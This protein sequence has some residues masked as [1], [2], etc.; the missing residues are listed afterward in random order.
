[1]SETAGDTVK[2]QKES[3]F[4]KTRKSQI[5]AKSTLTLTQSGLL[6]VLL[7]RQHDKAVELAERRAHRGHE[8][9]GF[10][11]AFTWLLAR[12]HDAVAGRPFDRGVA[13]TLP[14]HP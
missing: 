9:S 6:A 3:G 1:M 5:L 12:A 13:W 14:R 11:S 4:M 8:R 7:R 10:S 2:P